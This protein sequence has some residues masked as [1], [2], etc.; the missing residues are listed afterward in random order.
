MSVLACGSG[1]Q[2][3]P[4]VTVTEQTSALACYDDGAAC[5]PHDSAPTVEEAC[6]DA[7]WVA[8]VDDKV[9]DCDSVEG[10][11]GTWTGEP[12]FEGAAGGEWNFPMYCVYE[13]EGDDPEPNVLLSTSWIQQASPDCMV[14]GAQS[15]SQDVSRM[16]DKVRE[17][18]GTLN[19]GPVSERTV[20]IAVVDS[21]PERSTRGPVMGNSRHGHDVAQISR[22]VA[23]PSAEGECPIEI[24]HH[25]ALPLI[26][27][28]QADWT[29]GGYFGTQ[30]QVARALY[31]S[32]DL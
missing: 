25:L 13:W 12:L 27:P 24:R 9:T 28:K 8:L 17:Q 16:A 6:L 14:V 30:S 7:Q 22:S 4:A 2:V 23:C 29:D 15:E 21:S 26:A 5:V 18:V 11:E 10:V 32:K 1:S 31:R 20:D 3:E 19:V